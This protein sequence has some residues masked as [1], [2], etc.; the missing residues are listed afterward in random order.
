L[1]AN[2]I[3]SHIRIKP[4][5]VAQLASRVQPIAYIYGPVSMQSLDCGRF[6]K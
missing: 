6:Q 4:M 1:L 3:D 2:N 5:L